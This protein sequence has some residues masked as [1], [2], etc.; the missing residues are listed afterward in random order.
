MVNEVEQRLMG[1]GCPGPARPAEK[2]G[3]PHRILEEA[4]LAYEFEVPE[5]ARVERLDLG[6]DPVLEGR[7]AV[8]LELV[9]GVQRIHLVGRVRRIRPEI[10]VM[11]VECVRHHLGLEAHQAHLLVQAGARDAELDDR[12][13]PR[14]DLLCQGSPPIEVDPRELPA[15]GLHLL[16]EVVHAVVVDDARSGI[17]R[18]DV[19]VGDRV[20]VLDRGHVRVAR[21]RHRR[22]HRDGDD[23]LVHRVQFL[24][25]GRLDETWSWSR[26]AATRSASSSASTSPRSMTR[27]TLPSSSSTIRS[28]T[29]STWTML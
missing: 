5:G 26:L 8:C 1:W 6:F 7:P 13:N 9:A 23:E 19:L 10:F 15:V 11:N 29:G 22:V 4:L 18:T 24:L 2:Q 12:I 16:V 27:T 14:T 21:I 17:D 20:R 3:R 25:V 28:A